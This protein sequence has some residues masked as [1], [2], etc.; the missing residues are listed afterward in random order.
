MKEPSLS[1]PVPRLTAR[2][3]FSFGM[4]TALAWS[5]A[6]LSL[7][8]VAGSPPPSRAAKV[9]IFPALVKTLARFASWMAFL[10]FIPA[11]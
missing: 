8:L 10:C 5:I 9:T 2:S 1:S 3:M 11:Q 7:K 4:L 6:S